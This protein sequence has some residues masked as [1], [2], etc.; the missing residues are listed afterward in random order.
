MAKI[1]IAGA[2]RL[3]FPLALALSGS[4]HEV[5]AIRRGGPR[6]GP[7]DIRWQRLDLRDPAAV[8]VLDRDFDL[9]IVILTPAGR[10]PEGYRQ[11]YR[12][13][14][15]NLLGHL[16]SSRN[17][18]SCLFV[19]ATSVYAQIGGEWVDEESPAE[20]GTYNGRSL[21]SAEEAVL[22][23]SPDPLIVRFAGIYGPERMRLVRQLE[24]PVTI[25]R[26]PPAYTNRVHQEDCVGILRYLAGLQL[27][28]RNSHRVYLGA[29][30]CPAP[31][32]EMM[33]WLAR[34]AGLPEPIPLDAADDA[35]RNKRCSNRRLVETGYRFS[36]PDYKS[37]YRAILQGTLPDTDGPPG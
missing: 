10:S 32:F 24:K 37:G 33:A 1:L 21:L 16:E 35:P 25:Q 8:R 31:K 5:T 9:V 34:A 20:P 4:G 11:I 3:G 7:A 22:G 19:S 23:W 13:A 12:G 30:H 6:D 17:R 2:G 28:G 29:D 14:L 15:D 26:T 18:P 36:Y 27:G